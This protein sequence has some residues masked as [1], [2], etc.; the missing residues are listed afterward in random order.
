M[1]I[2]S[3]KMATQPNPRR[4]PY[5]CAHYDSC[6][7]NRCPLDSLIAK[8]NAEPGDPKCDMPKGRRRNYWKQMSPEEQALL[9]YQGYFEGEFKRIQ[10]H[11]ARW[12]AMSPP[13]R[14]EVLEKLAKLRQRRRELE[15]SPPQSV[16][17]T[18]T[19]PSSQS[20]YQNQVNV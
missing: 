13:Q 18:T 17:N 4:L 8:R 6:S 2:L 3:D 19:G 20:P 12:A 10:A 7:A 16:N 9:P 14:Q 15:A 11:N 5:Y 1:I